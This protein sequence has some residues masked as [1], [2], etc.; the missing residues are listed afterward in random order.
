MYSTFGECLNCFQFG[1]IS[2]NAVVHIL[3][4]YFLVQMYLHLHGIIARSEVS[5]H[6]SYMPPTLGADADHL[7]LDSPRWYRT[8]PATSHSHQHLALYFCF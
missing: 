8:L 3:L 1:P 4:R 7:L 2:N 5:L 6:T